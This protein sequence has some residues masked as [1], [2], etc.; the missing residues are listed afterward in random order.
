MRQEP[1]QRWPADLLPRSGFERHCRRFLSYWSHGLVL[2]EEELTQRRKG[3]KKGIAGLLRSILAQ[4]F[5]DLIGHQCHGGEM[6]Q[7]PLDN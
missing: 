6:E 5:K 7:Q 1:V 2:A 4:R 3:W